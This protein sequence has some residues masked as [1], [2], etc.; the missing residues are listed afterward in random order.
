[1]RLGEAKSSTGTGAKAPVCSSFLDR[2]KEANGQGSIHK[3]HEGEAVSAAGLR[4]RLLKGQERREGER[5]GENME[6]KEGGEER[7]IGGGMGRQRKRWKKGRRGR[8][9][10]RRGEER[11]GMI[12]NILRA[13]APT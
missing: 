1:M 8:R 3:H 7:G 4:G 5:E 13:L 6:E 11:E 12:P 9:E 2:R 10:R